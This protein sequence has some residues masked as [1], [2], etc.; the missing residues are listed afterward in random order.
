MK[1]VYIHQYF[2]TNKGKGGTRSYDVSKHMVRSG[3]EVHM[4]CGI[5]FSSDMKPM[6]WYQ[7]YR[8]EEVDG[9]KL[10]VLNVFCSNHH[11]MLKRMVSFCW[12]AFLATFA[13]LM[14]KKPDVIFATSTPLTVGIPGYI[15]A[16][17]KRAPLIFEVRDI[18]PEAL[19]PNTNLTGKEL[20]IR[21]LAWLERFIYKHSAKILLVS[22]GFEE[23]LIERG[24]PAEKLKTIFLGAEG[25]IFRDAK[26]DLE[27]MAKHGLQDK[28]VTVYTGAQGIIN[29]LDYIIDAAEHC[30]DRTDI[31]F[32]II[33]DGSEKKRL[34]EM[35]QKKALSNVVFIDLVSK[36]ALPGILAICHIGL[37]IFKYIG[38]KRRRTPNKVFDYMFTGMPS[39]INYTGATIDL[40]SADNSGL[41]VDPTKPEDLAE[42]VKELADNP[43][44]RKELGENGKRAAY[45]KYD[46]KII[47][48]QLIKVFEEVVTV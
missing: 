21:L 22:K 44:L 38:M 34:V 43:Q 25:D 37:V 24:F 29:G 27:F 41:Y 15:A 16:K 11:G 1:I 30:K 19:I 48:G 12:F 39:L 4:I 45:E 36:K 23:R 9:I 35:A 40:V 5:Y 7:L 10:T 46:R 32:L 31:V 3:H 28:I 20:S 2:M 8:N 42:K 17:L 13:A 18:W 26:P 33:G 14:S 6:P 47:A